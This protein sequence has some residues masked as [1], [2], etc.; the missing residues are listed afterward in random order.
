MDTIDSGLRITNHAHNRFIERVSTTMCPD[1]VLRNMWSA[2]RDASDIEIMAFG[3]S[4]RENCEYRVA[5]LQ[6]YGSFLLVVVENAM[7]TV[8]PPYY[9]FAHDHRKRRK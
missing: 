9:N 6:G 4:R 5:H 8:I 3:A 1:R 7:I 2:G